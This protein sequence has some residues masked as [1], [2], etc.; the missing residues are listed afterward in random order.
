[1]SQFLHQKE[2]KRGEATENLT[3]DVNSLM[4][5]FQTDASREH[6]KISVKTVSRS[7]SY[8]YKIQWSET[9]KFIVKG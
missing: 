4:L 6:C 8:T 2:R 5:V 1:M 3:L 7:Y 9:T